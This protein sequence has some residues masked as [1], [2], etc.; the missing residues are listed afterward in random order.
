MHYLKQYRAGKHKRSEF[1]YTQVIGKRCG[2]VIINERVGTNSFGYPI[3]LCTC[4]CC[5]REVKLTSQTVL[6]NSA[7]NCQFA[8]PTPP[9]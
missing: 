6:F 4:Q 7:V 1:D 3:F 9:R 5:G 8:R 2:D